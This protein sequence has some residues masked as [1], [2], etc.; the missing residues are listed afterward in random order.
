MVSNFYFRYSHGLKELKILKDHSIKSPISTL[1]FY[2]R[3]PCSHPL[4]HLILDILSFLVKIFRRNWVCVC[5]CVPWKRKCAKIQDVLRWMRWTTNIYLKTRKSL[6]VTFHV[7]SFQR[8]FLRLDLHADLLNVFEQ[9]LPQ[10]LLYPNPSDPLNG[11]AASLLLRSPDDYKR[12]VKGTEPLLG[13]T[14]PL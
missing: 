5:V 3:T 10:L 14:Y 13:F 9:F 8:P 7:S 11:E 2:T 1:H 4:S 6:G 12:K